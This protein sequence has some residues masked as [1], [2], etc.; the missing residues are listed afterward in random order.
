MPLGVK[1]G[2]KGVY[3]YFFTLF[4]D[5]LAGFISGNCQWDTIKAVISAYKRVTY[6]PVKGLVVIA[7]NCYL[8]PDPPR[9]KVYL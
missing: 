8:L 3:S 4:P 9:G 1:T 2:L 5:P 7:I 6:S